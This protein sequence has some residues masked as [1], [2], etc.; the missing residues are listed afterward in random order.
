MMSF[1]PFNDYFMAYS[2]LNVPIEHVF[3]RINVYDFCVCSN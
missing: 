2:W 3:L 1:A